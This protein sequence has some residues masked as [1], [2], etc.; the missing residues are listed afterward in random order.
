TPFMGGTVFIIMLF[1]WI[2]Q[3]ENQIR[4]FDVDR[5][6]NSNHSTQQLGH[7]MSTHLQKILLISFFVFIEI[8][9]YYMDLYITMGFIAVGIILYY[10]V[11]LIKK[12]VVIELIN[13]CIVVL[14][15]EHFMDTYNYHQQ[16]LFSGWTVVMILLAIIHV[17][18]NNTLQS[19]QHTGLF[20]LSMAE[21]ED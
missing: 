17:K 9:C 14:F 12:S 20:N 13:I 6:S 15:L 10:L 11:T 4:D 19:K 21:K 3:L 1:S 18:R 2:S 8:F 5:L 16:L 7:Q